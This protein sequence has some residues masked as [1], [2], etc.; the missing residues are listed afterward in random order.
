MVIFSSYPRKVEARFGEFWRDWASFGGSQNCPKFGPIIEL[1]MGNIF[2]V[3]FLKIPPISGVM[4]IFL[5]YI[6][7]LVGSVFLQSQVNVCTG[8]QGLCVITNQVNS[9]LLLEEDSRGFHFLQ[10]IRV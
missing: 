9:C 2:I 1:G 8:L 4:G 7:V 3:L 6:C 10:P 5:F